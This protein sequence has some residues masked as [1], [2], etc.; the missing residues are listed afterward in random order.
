M[1]KLKRF[2]DDNF[3]LYDLRIEIIGEEKQ[4]IC[5]HQKGESF[6]VHGENIIFNNCSKFS[7]YALSAILPL[8]PAKQRPTHKNDWMTTDAEIACPDPN[9]KARFKIT[10]LK[11]HSFKHSETT[12]V[13]LI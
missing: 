5:S 13:P 12:A 6:E 2:E 1:K 8:I 9:C 10:R 4:F 3:E 11:K 7:L